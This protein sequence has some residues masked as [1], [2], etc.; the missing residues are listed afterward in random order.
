MK[1][2]FLVVLAI[3]MLSSVGFAGTR[4]RNVDWNPVIKFIPASN[5]TG[6]LTVTGV[7]DGS[8]T[9]Y[10][11][12]TFGLIGLREVADGNSLSTLMRL[13]EVDVKQKVYTR[14]VWTTSVNATLEADRQVTWKVLYDNIGATAIIAPAT[15]LDTVITVPSTSEGVFPTGAYSINRTS[16]GIINANKLTDN[17]YVSFNVECDSASFVYPTTNEAYMLGLEVKYTPKRTEGGG[18]GREA[19]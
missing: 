4:D 18:L 2:L 15:A 5:F 1:K 14:V 3:I 11:I 16:W 7:A 6:F 12:S 8:P 13:S 9:L 17:G 10:E 19:R